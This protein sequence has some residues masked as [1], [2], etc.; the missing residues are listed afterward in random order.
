MLQLISLGW[1]KY[2]LEAFSAQ[3]G[4]TGSVGLKQYD[5]LCA[6]IGKCLTRQSDRD[7]PC[8][9]FPNGFS[10]GANL[11]GHEIEGCLLVKFFALHTTA[12][13]AIFLQERKPRER[14]MTMT[15][16]AAAA[17][18][19]AAMMNYHHFVMTNMF[20]IGFRLCRLSYSGT[21][22]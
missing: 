12:F 9:N 15:A 4:G 17:A 14:R 16:A 19:A 22:R 21:N 7:L 5:W 10:S 18:A 3:T 2:C 20:Q 1:C 13:Q 6:I 11:M 8:T